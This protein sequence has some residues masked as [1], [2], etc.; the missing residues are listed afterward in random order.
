MHGHQSQRDR[1]ATMS[2]IPAA[3]VTFVGHD[4]SPAD[5]PQPPDR[6]LSPVPVVL[7]A[8]PGSGERSP[9]EADDA[10]KKND[11]WASGEKMTLSGAI[12]EARPSARRGA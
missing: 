6:S 5:R 12:P 1:A 8:A 4:A 11:T 2:A 10:S 9:Q 7:P 3:L